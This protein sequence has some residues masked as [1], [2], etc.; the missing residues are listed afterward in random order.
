MDGHR[1]IMIT[2][3]LPTY[4]AGKFL[5]ACLQSLWDQSFQDF[6]I[7]IVENGSS[8]GTE[9]SVKGLR[10]DRVN[11]I[12][13]E[14]SIGFAA[15]ANIGAS[16]A[17][18]EFI[19]IINQ[20]VR[21]DRNCLAELLKIAK[22]TGA[23][24]VSGTLMEYD[25]SRLIARGARWLDVFGCALE[26][27]KTYEAFSPLWCYNGIALFNRQVFLN[28]L[29]HDDALNMYGDEVDLS[30]RLRAIGREIFSAPEAII[31]HARQPGRITAFVRYHTNRNA[32]VNIAKNAQHLLLVFLGTYTVL[33]M[34]EWTAILLLKRSLRMA[35]DCTLRA[36]RDAWRLRGHVRKCR[37]WLHP[38]R[39][40]SDFKIVLRFL[41]PGFGR[42]REIASLLRIT[43]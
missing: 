19:F 38:R 22:R 13:F 39:E 35:N 28:A 37:A 5:D 41:R 42:W 20:D 6:D 9:R 10:S 23:A 4:N 1:F 14:Q 16:A 3:I 31:Y 12:V 40:V 34:F 11:V 15:A 30:W 18:G 33:I 17:R 2:I 32:L 7:V 29:G 25:G 26:A 8:D 24:C 43:T 21:L 27:G 36:V